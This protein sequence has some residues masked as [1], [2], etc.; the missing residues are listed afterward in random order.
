MCQK[1]IF[2]Q[3]ERV[4]TFL[5]GDYNLRVINDLFVRKDIATRIHLNK[6]T[7]GTD[8][9]VNEKDIIVHHQLADE[10]VE[11]GHR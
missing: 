3:N 10:T 8:D 7:E 6:E 1:C 11:E 5:D 4:V 9:L 2:F